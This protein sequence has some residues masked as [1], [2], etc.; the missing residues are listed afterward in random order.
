MGSIDI[1]ITKDD[2]SEG[3]NAVI[4]ALTPGA[5]ELVQSILNM[6][7]SL[8]QSIAPKATGTLSESHIYELISP[9]EGFMMPTVPYAEY[10]IY[11]TA[12][13]SIGSPV[14]IGKGL[15]DWRYIGLSP[16][17]YETEQKISSMAPQYAQSASGGGRG[18]IHP[19]TPG[20]D[21][22]SEI[23]DGS[24]AG[25]DSYCDEYL[26]KLQEAWSG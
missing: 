8:A 21:Y 11:P 23:L 18:K 19:G 10:V 22:L 25:V 26:N 9:L 20:Q 16:G 1:R 14:F 4:T 7:M 6:W 17:K 15:G 5:S 13:H 12:P 24:V 2:V 3:L